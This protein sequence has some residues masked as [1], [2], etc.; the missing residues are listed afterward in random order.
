MDAVEFY[1]KSIQTAAWSSTPNTIH[2]KVHSVEY[3]K[4]IK[5][6]IVLKRKARKRW[7][8]SRYPPDKSQLNKISRD[9]DKLLQND[10]SKK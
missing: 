3:S 10:K 9:L 8:N 6:M 5:Q 2:K 7:Q 4:E 1:T